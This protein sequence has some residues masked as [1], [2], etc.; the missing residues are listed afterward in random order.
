MRKIAANAGVS[1]AS[2]NYHFRSKQEL[3]NEI[4]ISSH[5][6]F[7]QIIEN[8]LNETDTFAEAVDKIYTIALNADQMR[9]NH[10]MLTNPTAFDDKSL[11]EMKKIFTTPPGF[12]ILFSK[13]S[14]E[15]NKQDRPDIAFWLVNNAILY[16]TIGLSGHMKTP[17]WPH[18]FTK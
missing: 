2:I 17:S 7:A 9:N 10:S 6:N 13:V 15:I 8:T 14:K 1:L 12:K 11:S 18:S 5:T 3:Y 16:V 4:L